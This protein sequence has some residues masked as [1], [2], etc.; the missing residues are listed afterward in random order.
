M[1]IQTDKLAVYRAV[2]AAESA[3]PRS[4]MSDAA[5]AKLRT[6]NERDRLNAEADARLVKEFNSRPWTLEQLVDLFAKSFGLAPTSVP[7]DPDYKTNYAAQWCPRRRA[8]KAMYRLAEGRRVY[9]IHD[10]S[11][12]GELLR[13]ENAM[14]MY[15]FL[16]KYP[17]PDDET[18]IPRGD[19]P[20]KSRRSLEYKQSQLSKRLKRKPRLVFN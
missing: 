4:K 3:E 13:G 20:I 14:S 1:D 18:V 7:D 12:F 19:S 17:L 10:L 11:F 2:V 9:H 5:K 16:A 15:K 8:I 6:L